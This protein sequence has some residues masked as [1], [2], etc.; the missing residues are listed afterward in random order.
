MS[1]KDLDTDTKVLIV[2]V[3]LCILMVIAGEISSRYRFPGRVERCF[4][5]SEYDYEV[6]QE[7]LCSDYSDKCYTKVKML[8]DTYVGEHPCTEWNDFFNY[9]S[10]QTAVEGEVNNSF[11]VQKSG[12]VVMHWG[13]FNRTDRYR[14]TGRASSWE[15]I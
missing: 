11:E 12:N 14:C 6:C 4:E 10:F 8:F 2:V 15:E 7:Q 9:T 3:A 13:R 1:W 5:S